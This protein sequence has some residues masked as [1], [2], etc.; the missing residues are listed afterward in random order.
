MS[1]IYTR[2]AVMALVAICASAESIQLPVGDYDACRMMEN[3]PSDDCAFMCPENACVIPGNSCVDGLKDCLCKQG[4]YMVKE[5]KNV[6]SCVPVTGF[7][8]EQQYPPRP[9]CRFECPEGSCADQTQA[10][11]DSIDK[12]IC[13]AGYSMVDGECVN[14]MGEEAEDTPDCM[15]GYVMDGDICVAA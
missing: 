8:L 15:D 7:C 10:C 9:A 13:Q 12:C 14:S 6:G 11:V 4:W 1:P 5:S 3:P 2:V